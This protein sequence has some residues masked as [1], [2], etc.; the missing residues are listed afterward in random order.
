[1]IP[2]EKNKLYETE[3]GGLG[4]GGEGVGQVDGFKIFVPDALPSE[5]ILVKIREVKKNYAV[6]K[7]AKIFSASADRVQPFCP[8]YGTCGGCQLQ[9]MNYPAQL[10]TKYRRVRDAVERIGKVRALEILDVLGAESVRHY[11]NKMQFPIG[12]KKNSVAIGCFARGSHEI[13][14]TASCMIQHAGNNEI[15]R[16]VRKVVGEL[17]IPPYD[18]KTRQG[19]LRHVMGRIGCGGELMIVLVTAKKFLPDEKKIVRE[20][21]RELPKVASIQQNIQSNPTNV[22]LGNETKILFGSPTIREKIFGLTFDISAKSFFQVNTAQTEVLYN[23]VKNFAE[24]DG[25]ETILDAYCGIGTISLFLAKFAKKIYGVEIEPA[26]VADAKKNS[27]TNKISNSEFFAGDATELVPKLLAEGKIFD[28][29]VVDP[30]RSGCNQKLLETL[31]AARPKKI[32]YVSC[33]PST[34]ARDIKILSEL[35]YSTKKIQ[36]VDMF[37]YTSHVESVAQIFRS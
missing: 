17:K 33:N 37:P 21:L 31:A 22:I 11:R 1:M 36:P 15:L 18:E 5:K 16:A 35:D 32:I 6:G 10:A 4:S 12:R 20:L 3:I 7:I 19:I 2:V 24:L 30:P 9:H 23:V 29:A 25:T 34:L 14:D 27:L 28:V 26:A 8:V 13:V